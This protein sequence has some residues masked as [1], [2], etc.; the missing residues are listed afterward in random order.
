LRAYGGTEE[1]EWNLGG[2]AVS[3]ILSEAG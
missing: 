3:R 1:G 2:S